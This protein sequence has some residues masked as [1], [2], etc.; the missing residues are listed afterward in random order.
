MGW[1]EWVALS[2]LGLPAIK[3]KVD[4]GARTSALHA[5]L[6]EP[7]G[8]LASPMVRFGV[9][10]IPGRD[11]IEIYCSAPVAGRRDVTSSNGEKE[12]RVFIRSPI[13]I[14]TRSW[15][16]EIGLTNRESMSYRMLLGRQA[17][18]DDMMVD[19]AASFRQPRL[20]YKLYRN[21]PR[22]GR[23]R[24]ALR[25]AVLGRATAGPSIRRLAAAA[26][27]R[28]HVLECLDLE[29][30]A[31]TFDDLVPGLTL[32]GAALA[33][34]DA[35]IPRV[36]VRDGAHGAALVRQLELMGSY[37][38]NSGDALDRR[39][40]RV[41]VVQALTRA[42]IAHNLAADGRAAGDPVDAAAVDTSLHVLLVG[43]RVTAML[44]GGDGV[45][46]EC[47]D[48]RLVDAQALAERTAAALDLEL[49]AVAIEIGGETPRVVALSARPALARFERVTGA[50]A[51]P[52][53]I[54]L[55]EARVRSWV[56]RAEAG[57]SG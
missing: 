14:G 30:L 29:R 53:I 48:S 5:F 23:V 35:V 33:H 50:G 46:V 15:T 7:F 21:L 22:R 9:H 12:S 55:I 31:L 10:P 37:A 18:S 13:E 47:D 52:A 19:P 1:E 54:S 6:I 49:V 25:I 11:D 16:I 34:Y 3:A 42:G 57:G 20:S 27:A 26:L 39:A 38:V 56:R 17:I 2:A 32:D 41:A 4:T 44:Q 36:G 45:N 43:G 8:T 24:R 40:N 28:G 51:A